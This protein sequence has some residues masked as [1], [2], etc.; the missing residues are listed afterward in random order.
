VSRIPGVLHADVNFASGIML[1]E[2]DVERD[3]RSRVVSTVVGAGHGIEPL[4]A[5]DSVIGPSRR[6][7][8]R[9]TEITLAV[10]GALIVLGHLLDRSGH[11]VA[12]AAAFGLAIMVGGT[13][14]GERHQHIHVERTSRQ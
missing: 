8:A 12:A 1:F 13:R 11:T 7:T 3:P 4:D 2:Y 9:R 6:W 14:H 10:S 5:R